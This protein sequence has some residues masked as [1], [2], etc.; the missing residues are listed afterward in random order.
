MKRTTIYLDP[1]LELWLKIE[2]RRQ[3]VPMAELIRRTLRKQ[4]GKRSRTLPPG[5]GEYASER[6]D[7][8][9]RA[10]EVLAES[11]FGED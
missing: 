11:G 5:I 8:A 9:E 1:D 2:A 10:E 7:V 3:N 4:A 6:G